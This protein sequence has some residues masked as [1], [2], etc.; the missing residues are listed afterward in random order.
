MEREW[1]ALRGALWGEQDLVRSG[2]EFETRVLRELEAR[3][4]GSLDESELDGS[5][6]SNGDR[7]DGA[8]IEM[9]DRL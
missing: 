4:V 3:S 1:G 5:R 7:I 9:S 2:I 6:E 8:V